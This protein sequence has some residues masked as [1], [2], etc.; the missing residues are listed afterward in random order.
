MFLGLVDKWFAVMLPRM[1][2]F[3]VENG[4]PVLMVQVS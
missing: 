2:P 3:L 4:G 1:R